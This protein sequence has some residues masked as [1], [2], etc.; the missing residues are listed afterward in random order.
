MSSEEGDGRMQ[1]SCY[2]EDVRQNEFLNASP[3]RIGV[4]Q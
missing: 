3:Q 4:D 1:L 2:C